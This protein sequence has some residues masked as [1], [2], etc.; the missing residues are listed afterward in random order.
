MHRKKF[1]KFVKFVLHLFCMNL[2]PRSHAS[3]TNRTNSS[4]LGHPESKA[5]IFSI[6]K[7]ELGQF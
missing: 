4:Y 6:I 7:I 3:R 5:V 2:P 1:N